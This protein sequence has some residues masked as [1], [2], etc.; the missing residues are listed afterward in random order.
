MTNGSR[1]FDRAASRENGGSLMPNKME[2]L[3][4]IHLFW[5]SLG[6]SGGLVCCD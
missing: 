6:F 2:S 1:Q 4:I 3:A 5:N